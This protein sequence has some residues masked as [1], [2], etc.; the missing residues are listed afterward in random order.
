MRVKMLF[1]LVALFG[2]LLV[3]LFRALGSYF[4]FFLN[5]NKSQS[6]LLCDLKNTTYSFYFVIVKF[7][8]FQAR[9]CYVL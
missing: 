2:L 8:Q 1:S 5:Y 3:W 4:F 9:R 6:L 7:Q